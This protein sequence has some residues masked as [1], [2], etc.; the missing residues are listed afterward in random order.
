MSLLGSTIDLSVEAPRLGLRISLPASAVV[1]RTGVEFAGT[2]QF[3][4]PGDVYG[5]VNAVIDFTA[6]R[7]T[8]TID[9][10]RYSSFSSAEF[11]GYVLR[12]TAGA[13]PALYSARVAD[14]GNTLGLEEGD[15]SVVGG[16]LR[17]NVSGLRFGNGDGFTLLL[18]FN[19]VGDS[20]R[21]TL[22]GGR[23][24][25]RLSGGSGNDVL[26][27]GRGEDLLVGGK[28]ADLFV[29]DSAADS[30]NWG[31][32]VIDGF[33]AAGDRWGDRIDLREI[34][35][36]V[37]VRGEQSFVFGTAKGAGRLWAVDGAN[38]DTVILGNLDADS[39]A[40]F[41][42]RI[43]DGSQTAADY[44]AADFLL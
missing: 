33:S 11:N 5:I 26:A 8:Y 3:D 29:F 19:Y 34:D 16:A 7:M 23:Y 36:N 21:N 9:T 31:R 32:D 18:G 37:G 41:G 40:E 39:R 24:D 14:L 1:R 15:L 44:T 2:A 35:A 22:T 12:K 17:V 4:R 30:P 42:I 6:D 43:R 20:G 13:G 38:G 10:T 28:G 27:G 25:D